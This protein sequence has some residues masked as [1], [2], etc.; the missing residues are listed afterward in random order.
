MRKIKPISHSE[1]DERGRKGKKDTDNALGSYYQKTA[2]L[3]HK[4]WSFILRQIYGYIRRKRYQSLNISKFLYCS[5]VIGTGKR[6]ATDKQKTLYFLFGKLKKKKKKTSSDREK[7]KRFPYPLEN[8]ETVSQKQRIHPWF[9]GTFQPLKTTQT[10][11]HL[12]LIPSPHQP[13][14]HHWLLSLP[15]D[16]KHTEQQRSQIKSRKVQNQRQCP[17]HQQHRQLVGALSSCLSTYIP[18][19]EEPCTQRNYPVP[20][21]RY[22]RRRSICTGVGG[23]CI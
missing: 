12:V 20:G 17:G 23:V 6:K 11:I 1:L 15:P 2:F 16:A 14:S 13:Y 7:N 9:R 4:T 22:A 8:W 18:F 3:C 19:Q 5:L 10:L 21:L